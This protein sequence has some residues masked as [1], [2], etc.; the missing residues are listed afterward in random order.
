MKLWL[1]GKDTKMHSTHNK[2][3]SVVPERCFRTS[4]NKIYKYM[5]SISQS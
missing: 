1:Q 2:G 5:N 3:K 4:K